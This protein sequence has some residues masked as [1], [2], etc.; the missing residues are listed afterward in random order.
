MLDESRELA[1]NVT[2]V[3]ITDRPQAGKEI[4][5]K[6]DNIFLKESDYNLYIL[7]DG[8]IYRTSA[9]PFRAIRESEL[10]EVKSPLPLAMYIKANHLSRP[11]ESF[12]AFDLKA[13]GLE[14]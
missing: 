14:I 7:K 3:K 9:V 12:F 5:M 4:E 11:L 2:T 13:Y 1:Y 6:I 10:Q 8:K